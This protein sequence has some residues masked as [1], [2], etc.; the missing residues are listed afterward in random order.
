MPTESLLL[1]WN[2]FLGYEWLPRVECL[3]LIVNMNSR[4]RTS[5]MASTGL[6]G[7]SL[8][9]CTGLSYLCLLTVHHISWLSRP[10]LSP[11]LTNYFKKVPIHWYMKFS[12]LIFFLITSR[13]QDYH[14]LA[15][16]FVLVL[17]L[18]QEE[19]TALIIR[20]V[21]SW[22]LLNHTS[23]LMVSMLLEKQGSWHLVLA[24]YFDSIIIHWSINSINSY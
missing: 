8:Y 22:N 15:I 24:F 4:D 3:L 1:M 10:S 9:L 19:L 14:S 17:L 12:S 6:L 20:A 11:I 21:Q 5:P 23:M 16:S 13:L 2:P 18:S 7:I